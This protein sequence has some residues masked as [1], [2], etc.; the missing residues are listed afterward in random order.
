MKLLILSFVTSW[1]LMAGGDCC[2]TTSVP[3]SKTRMRTLPKTLVIDQDGR[4]RAF[5][6][7]IASKA[8]AINFIYTACRTVC[9]PMAA[10]FASL[11][12]E[13]PDGAR[14][15]SVSLDP[16]T[17]TPARLR[18]WGEKFGRGPKWVLLTG[19]KNEIET[20]L[21]ALGVF[22]PLKESHAPILM[23]GRG[24]SWTLTSGLA[25]PESILKLMNDM[26]GAP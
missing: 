23:V 22:T 6:D 11:Q 4:Q 20:L 2:A 18:A 21:K 3:E 17:D 25:P 9:P 13:L 12:R 8:V 14:L 24:Q 26:G 10:N 1:T 16:R 19:E 5:S 7:L 15:I